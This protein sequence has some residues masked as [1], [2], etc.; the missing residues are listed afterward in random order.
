LRW[1]RFPGAVAGSIGL[2]AALGACAS[3]G[4]GEPAAAVVAEP[5]PQA[6]STKLLEPAVSNGSPLTVV[7]VPGGGLSSAIYLDDRGRGWASLLVAAG[8]R[9]ILVDPPDDAAAPRWTVA[10]AFPVW[11]IQPGGQDDGTPSRFDTSDAVHVQRLLRSPGEALSPD[12]LADILAAHSPTVV[13]GHSFGGRT[14]I[15]AAGAHPDVKGIVLVEPL[16][17]PT[18]P[19]RLQS[20]FVQTGRSLL[21]IWGDNL[22]RGAPS[23]VSRREACLNASQQIAASGGEACVLDLPAE[24]MSGNSHLMM[25][26][27]NANEIAAYVIRWLSRLESPTQATDLCGRPIGPVVAS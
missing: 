19:V 22:D 11:G 13:I 15:E 12:A 27:D 24:G 25:V 5:F 1:R 20:T 3:R 26:E 21:T 16:A 2:A 6:I 17:C 4:S 9:V 18:E 23:M 7:M 10:D 8:Y 14:A